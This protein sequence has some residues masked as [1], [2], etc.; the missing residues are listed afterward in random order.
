MSF[1]ELQDYLHTRKP[2]QTLALEVLSGKDSVTTVPAALRF[3]GTEYPWSTP[4]GFSNSVLAMLQHLIERDPLSDEAKFASLS[5]ARGLMRWGEWK[6]ALGVLAKSNLEPHKTG[7]CPGTVLYY[8][9]RC[10]E[11]LGDRALAESYYARARDYPGATLG[12][13]DGISI[14][15]LAERRIQSLKKPAR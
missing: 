4:D 11:E 6:L 12:T 10:Y 14:A 2:G 1:K 5:L 15:G 13:P 8:Q 9:G 3:L 7:I